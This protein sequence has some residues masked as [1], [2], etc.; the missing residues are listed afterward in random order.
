M[1]KDSVV[2]KDYVSIDQTFATSFGFHPYQSVYV[3][4]VDAEV[5]YC[6]HCFI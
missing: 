3:I 5:K 2:P 4:Q 1:L 6:V